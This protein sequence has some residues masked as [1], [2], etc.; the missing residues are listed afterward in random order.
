MS[1]QNAQKPTLDEVI[2]DSKEILGPDLT[3]AKL[4]WERLE[5]S[6]MARVE[7]ES[8]SRVAR[9][10]FAGRRGLWGGVAAALA[11]AAS[12]PMFLSHGAE[13]ALDARAA[14]ESHA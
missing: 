3:G 2:R 12:V 14:S 9:A 4:D 1:G 11:I 10:R 5:S 6:L 13:T 7:T 8:R